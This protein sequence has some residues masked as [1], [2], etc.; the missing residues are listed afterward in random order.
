VIGFGCKH[1]KEK[2]KFYILSQHNK[3]GNELINGKVDSSKPLIPPAPQYRKWF[4]NL[5]F[6]MD[7]TDR[8]YL[9]QAEMEPAKSKMKST[10]SLGCCKTE[11]KAQEQVD[12]K[13]IY[14]YDFPNYT[15]LRPE[16]LTAIDSRYII[17]F[18]KLNM[19][20]FQLDTNRKGYMLFYIASNEDTICNEAFYELTKFV[21]KNI[22]RENHIFY[23][24][25]P[26][27]EEE[28]MVIYHKRRNI[29]YFPEKINWTTNFINGK[30]KPFTKEYNDIE[31]KTDVLYKAK[32]TFKKNSLEYHLIM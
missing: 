10:N 11:R 4:T 2:R 6:I 3:D 31:Y 25:R 13:I 21:S 12:D 15:G 23:L 19:D 16:Y 17:P 28:N 8:V 7:S 26:T 32:E 9:Y 20:I 5:V 1:E 14:N 18:L 29:D 30:A 24:V 27:T 22:S